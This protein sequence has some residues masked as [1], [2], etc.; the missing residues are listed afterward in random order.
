MRDQSSIQNLSL[1]SLRIRFL[2]AKLIKRWI[3]SSRVT[4]AKN[5]QIL[6]FSQKKSSRIKTLKTSSSRSSN[7]VRI[8]RKMIKRNSR[9]FRNSWEAWF[10]ASYLWKSWWMSL[11][12]LP[13]KTESTCSSKGPKEPSK[14]QKIILKRTTLE[15]A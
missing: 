14:F 13:R 11:W 1:L 3:L 8:K 10:S 2:P 6:S 12:G 9:A 5:K 7:S 15:L 4:R